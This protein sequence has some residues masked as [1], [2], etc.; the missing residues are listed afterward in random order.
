MNQKLKIRLLI[1]N[2]QALNKAQSNSIN[3]N[4]NNEN[5]KL[6]NKSRNDFISNM[7]DQ[8]NDSVEE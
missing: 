7:D 5:N 4:Q 3:N 1:N 6:I 8:N 2:H